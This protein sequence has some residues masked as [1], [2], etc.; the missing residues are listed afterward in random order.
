MSH[1]IWK[2]A[3][4]I[5]HQQ[6]VQLPAGAQIMHVDMQSGIPCIWFMVNTLGMSS[7]REGRHIR[8]YGTGHDIIEDP[9]QLT[10]LSTVMDGSYVW[11]FFEY[12][13]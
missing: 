6:L 5:T 8:C 12:K 2:Q 7:F 9:K 4:E 3:I 1:T 11:H 10:H 13:P